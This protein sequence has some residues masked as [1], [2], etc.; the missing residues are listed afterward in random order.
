MQTN[1]PAIS[2]ISFL[3]RHII[4]YENLNT[5]EGYT[6]INPDMVNDI[7]EESSKISS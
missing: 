7:L 5:L 3:I 4:G 1:A 6:D 2:D